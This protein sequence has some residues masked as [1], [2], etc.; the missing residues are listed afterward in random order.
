MQCDHK[1]MMRRKRLETRA[2]IRSRVEKLKGLPGLYA[3]EQQAIDDAL[4]AERP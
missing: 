4:N 1:P 3:A 2:A